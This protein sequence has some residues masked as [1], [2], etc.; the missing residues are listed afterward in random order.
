MNRF[1]EIWNAGVFMEYNKTQAG[2]SK[3]DMRSVDTG[4]GLERITM[5]LNG[6]ASCYE[7]D[8][9]RPADGFHPGAARNRAIATRRRP[10]S[11]PIIFAPPP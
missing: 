11:S 1:I 2:M 6:F 9:L 4:S 7:T 10:A 5:T 8:L 3:L